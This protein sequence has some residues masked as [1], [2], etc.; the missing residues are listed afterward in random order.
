[1]TTAVPTPGPWVLRADSLGGQLGFS[2]KVDLPN[3][4]VAFTSS[5]DD[6]S[7]ANARLIAAAPQLLKALEASEQ[8]IEEAT[9][10]MYYEDGQ[11]VTA[12]EGW[13]IER[14]Y[15]ALCSVLVE[16]ERAITAAGGKP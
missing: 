7:E 11:P 6:A 16:V 9:G 1:M 10:I 5:N 15:V 8:A 3:G 13:E 12:L 2:F 14:A 4:A